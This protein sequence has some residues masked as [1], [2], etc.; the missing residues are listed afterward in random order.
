MLARGIWSSNVVTVAHARVSALRAA[1]A[2]ASSTIGRLRTASRDLPSTL[3]LQAHAPATAR[4]SEHAF[5]CAELSCCSAL[6]ACPSPPLHL[7]GAESETGL[8]I[9][10]RFWEDTNGFTIKTWALLYATRRYT[11]LPEK[12][13]YVFIRA[14]LCP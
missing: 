6:V 13:T 14:N 1:A 8:E 5:C 9:A 4:G 10:Q 2:Q 12:N 7:R 11:A 3:R